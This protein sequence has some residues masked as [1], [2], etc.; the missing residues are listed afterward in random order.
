MPPTEVTRHR[1]HG[2]HIGKL[3]TYCTRSLAADMLCY[4]M[5]TTDS[6]AMCMVS[7]STHACYML[8]V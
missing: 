3:E 5:G 8:R 2:T 4:F 7:M 6:D 1:G